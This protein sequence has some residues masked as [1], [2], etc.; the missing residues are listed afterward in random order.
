M[1]IPPIDFPFSL[2]LG[3]C[4]AFGVCLAVCVGRILS[5][6]TTN[7]VNSEWLLQL[8]TERYRPMLRLLG[9]DDVAFLR[10]Q[11]GFRPP[12]A[13]KLRAQRCQIL[14]GYLR[15]LDRDFRYMCAG[16]KTLMVQSHQDR[17]DLARAL[18]RYQFSFSVGMIVVRAKMLCYRMGLGTVDVAN[19]V[20]L[21]DLTRLQLRNL[22]PVSARA[23]L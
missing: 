11:P 7:Q 12:M 5:R 17:P 18:F 23:T 3:I 20:A 13:A 21:F 6:D 1:N 2:I 16:I 19:L 4:L 14:C 22:A 10:A 15:S 9:D 8:S